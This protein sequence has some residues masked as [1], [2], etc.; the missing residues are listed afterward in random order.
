MDSIENDWRNNRDARITPR[1]VSRKFML[2]LFCLCNCS[3][4]LDSLYTFFLFYYL[5]TF[6]EIPSLNAGFI[7]FFSVILYVFLGP[8]VA[9]VM[10]LWYIP[11][12]GKHRFW[13]LAASIPSCVSF[14]L[15]WFVPQMSLLGREAYVLCMTT[16]FNI[17]YGVLH[18]AYESLFTLMASDGDELVK[19]NTRRLAVGNLMTLFPAIVGSVLVAMLPSPEIA[20]LVS[21]GATASL[22]LVIYIAFVNCIVEVNFPND[23]HIATLSNENSFDLCAESCPTT[24]STDSSEL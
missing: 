1:F 3:T 13:L 8:V 20:F 19:L 12:F 15:I 5:T 7:L 22:M 16:A 4:M 23:K 9:E 21:A 24:I 14:T 18:V 6:Y 11:T 2:I 10:D 17:C